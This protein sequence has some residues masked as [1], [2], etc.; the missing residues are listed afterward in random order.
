MT[1][2]SR[3]ASCIKPS[4]GVFRT[5]SY[6]QYGDFA[7]IVNSFKYFW[8]KDVWLGSKYTSSLYPQKSAKMQF[9]NNLSKILHKF[10]S[11]DFLKKALEGWFLQ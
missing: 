5:Q 1:S 10:T 7:K 11:L 4:K 9:L 2:S 6:I 8:K 3:G